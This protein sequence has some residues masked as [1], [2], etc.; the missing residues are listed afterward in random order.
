[1]ITKRIDELNELLEKVHQA[2]LGADWLT[3]QELYELEDKVKQ[4][5]Q[6]EVMKL[7]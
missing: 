2:V 3:R 4:E 7:R 5:L 1:M 6:T